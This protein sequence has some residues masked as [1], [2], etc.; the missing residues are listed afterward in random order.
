MRDLCA[1]IRAA[2]AERRR[3]QRDLRGRYG[4]DFCDVLDEL[5]E[6]ETTLRLLVARLRRHRLTQRQEV[7]A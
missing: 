1:R 5:R 6:V 4:Q 7:A 3:L 2:W